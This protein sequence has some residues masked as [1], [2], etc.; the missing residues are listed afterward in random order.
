MEPLSPKAKILLDKFTEDYPSAGQRMGGINSF[1]RLLNVSVAENP[2]I[3]YVGYT[4]DYKPEEGSI[5]ITYG[6]EVY[7]PK[8]KD[9]SGS[10]LE[11]QQKAISHFAF[12]IQNARKAAIFGEQSK[13]MW[14]KTEAAVDAN[15]PVDGPLIKSIGAEF[16]QGRV[17]QETLNS[18]RVGQAWSESGERLANPSPSGTTGFFLDSYRDWVRNGDSALQRRVNANL[19]DEYDSG[20]YK[21]WTRLELFQFQVRQ[22]AEFIYRSRGVEWPP[23][24]GPSP[25]S[26]FT[27]TAE[28]TANDLDLHPVD[29]N[30]QLQREQSLGPERGFDAAVAQLSLAI[31]GLGRTIANGNGVVER[32]HQ[33]LSELTSLPTGIIPE[34]SEIVSIIGEP[35]PESGGIE[36]DAAAFTQALQQRTQQAL[37]SYR[38]E[39][40]EQ[41]IEIGDLGRLA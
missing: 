4:E 33:Q 40:S 30:E 24:I 32:S 34:A 1:R 17:T 13:E 39:G 3:V 28:F 22:R 18:F 14:A 16:A 35:E 27:P 8:H 26:E 36:Q 37:A 41:Q 25:Q 29:T 31:E 9:W 2:N 20:R 15:L 21:G 19:K 6:N 38:P 11:A 23:T 10:S 12:E 5:P 7:M